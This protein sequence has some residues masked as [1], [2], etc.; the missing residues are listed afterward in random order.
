M[1]GSYEAMLSIYASQVTNEGRGQDAP[2]ASVILKSVAEDPH[3]ELRPCHASDEHPSCLNFGVLVGGA[4][5]GRSL[6]LINKGRAKVPLQFSINSSVSSFVRN[7]VVWM[8]V[9]IHPK[10][11]CN[12]EVSSIWWDNVGMEP[13]NSVSTCHTPI[14]PLKPLPQS[15]LL[16]TLYGVNT[17][18]QSPSLPYQA[19]F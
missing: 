11:N 16:P 15:F 18:Y 3:V 7:S 1:A 2:T 10:E 17:L 4:S 6:E 13:Q 5:V 14:F 8:Y 12:F 9:C 19:V